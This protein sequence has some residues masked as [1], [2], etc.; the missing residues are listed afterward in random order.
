MHIHNMKIN[1]NIVIGNCAVLFS[2]PVFIT[3]FCNLWSPDFAG[4]PYILPKFAFLNCFILLEPIAQLQDFKQ[5]VFV[6]FLNLQLNFLKEPLFFLEV[7]LVSTIC[8][9]L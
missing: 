3:I 8:I 4:T 5:S 7:V 1:I 2:F 9:I 6:A